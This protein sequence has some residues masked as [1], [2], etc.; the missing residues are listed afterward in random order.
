[1]KK[2][3]LFF[4]CVG[5]SVST[6]CSEKTIYWGNEKI[7]IHGVS[8]G[9]LEKDIIEKQKR[10]EQKKRDLSLLAFCKKGDLEGIKNC[11]EKEGANVNFVTWE[12]RTSSWQ[13]PLS[14]CS[15]YEEDTSHIFEKWHN[16]HNVLK[17]GTEL[18]PENW[19]G[20]AYFYDDCSEDLDRVRTVERQRKSA[21]VK[22][23]I[24]KG[25]DLR[26]TNF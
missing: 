10:K 8:A 18:P 26:L 25:T 21:M 5:F 9:G 23:L 12:R 2:I 1:M 3:F 17:N 19:E 7:I 20:I 11:V 13:T 14:A 16:E 15:E 6:F 24:E 4:L 22:Y